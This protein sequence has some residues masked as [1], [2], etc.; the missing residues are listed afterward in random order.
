MSAAVPAAHVQECNEP[1]LLM[2]VNGGDKATVAALIEAGADVNAA[3][4]VRAV[5]VFSGFGSLTACL[6]PAV[7]L[8]TTA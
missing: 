7:W 2:A 4:D 8:D 5:R 3:D 1:L 6:S